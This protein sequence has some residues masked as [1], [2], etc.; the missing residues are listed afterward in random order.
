MAAD[1]GGRPGIWRRAG[2][3]GVP[4]GLDWGQASGLIPAGADRDRVLALLETYETGLLE[5]SAETARRQ[6]EEQRRKA[7]Q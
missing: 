5:G 6:A 3:A 7:Q 2:Q 4:C 1:I